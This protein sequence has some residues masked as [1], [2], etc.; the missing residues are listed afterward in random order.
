MSGM[1]FVISRSSVQVRPPAP[2]KTFSKVADS[3]GWRYAV[4]TQQSAIQ[5]A[6]P[7]ITVMLL[8]LWLLNLALYTWWEE[9]TPVRG[10]ASRFADRGD[11]RAK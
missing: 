5:S 2:A 7:L 8:T 10:T 9:R 4:K 6:I 11:L 1:K 3:E